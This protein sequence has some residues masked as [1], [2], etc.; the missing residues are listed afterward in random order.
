MGS[1]SPRCYNIILRVETAT[2]TQNGPCL[3]QPYPTSR[4]RPDN[5]HTDH[6]HA[7]TAVVGNVEISVPFTVVMY[8]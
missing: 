1:E 7:E 6:F 5:S 8:Q 3:K 4:H 2:D